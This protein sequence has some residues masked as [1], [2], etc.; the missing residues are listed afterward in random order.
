VNRV[1]IEELL[2]R[3]YRA[4]ADMDVAVIDELVTDDMVMHVPGDHP[5][6][7]EHSG[8]DQVWAY[9]GK[10]A[11]V[12]GGAGGFEVESIA[13]DD[14]GHAAVILT[15]TIRD[16]VRPV[17][18]MWRAEQGKLVEYWEGNYDQA[19]EDAFWNVAVAGPGTSH[20]AANVAPQE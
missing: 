5:L 1:E 16:F 9:L 7:G 8:R 20:E 3:N 4:Y 15:G 17:V 11:E 2:R 6:S 13:A 12:S 10:V 18:H 14:E 19:A